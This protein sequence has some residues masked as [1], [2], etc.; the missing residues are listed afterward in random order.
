MPHLSHSRLPCTDSSSCPS[1]HSGATH[2]SGQRGEC[3]GLLFP[4]AYPSHIPPFP[5]KDS[6]EDDLSQMHL[7]STDDNT[8]FG[9]DL[10][11]SSR[12]SSSSSV[13]Q[14]GNANAGLKGKLKKKLEISSIRQKDHSGG[15]SPQMDESA[16]ST[17]NMQPTH[18]RRKHFRNP[19]HR[20]SI[21]F[22][23]HVSFHMSC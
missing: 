19:E 8:S 16:D 13:S 7:I 3:H 10:S 20:K 1:N 2:K 4:G 18:H 6:I 5:P 14:H 9:S 11:S 15:T 12:S 17:R 23:S 21:I 22:G